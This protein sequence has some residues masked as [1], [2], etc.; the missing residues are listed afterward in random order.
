ML[1]LAT[2]SVGQVI[3]QPLEV[4]V[5]TEE[6]MELM[7]VVLEGIMALQVPVD[8]GKYSLRKDMGLIF[9]LGTVFNKQEMTFDN[10]NNS[11]IDLELVLHFIIHII[12]PNLPRSYSMLR[13]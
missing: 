13:L 6:I 4:V 8:M 10:K 1:Q 12:F 7:E 5:D 2:L 9:F 3:L 11:S